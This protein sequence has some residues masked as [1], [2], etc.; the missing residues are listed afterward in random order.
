MGKGKNA[1]RLLEGTPEGKNHQEDQDVSGW[2]ILRSIFGK[3]DW[4]VCRWIDLTQD[5]D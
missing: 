1:Y 2:T 4:L 5:K 3:W